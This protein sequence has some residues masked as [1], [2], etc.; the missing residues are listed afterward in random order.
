[1]TTKSS[2]IYL[3]D[4]GDFLSV[5]S[6]GKSQ[7]YFRHK[8]KNVT[9]YD[10]LPNG[11]E[12]VIC[13]ESDYILL[14]DIEGNTINGIKTSLFGIDKIKVLALSDTQILIYFT[15]EY[16]T[17]Y[18]SKS[19]V[20]WDLSTNT[21]SSRTTYYEGI[22][23]NNHYNIDRGYKISNN[24][25]LM[26]HSGIGNILVNIQTGKT[27]KLDIQDTNNIRVFGSIVISFRGDKVYV[28]RIDNETGIKTTEI[29]GS[30]IFNVIDLT[31]DGENYLYIVMG[32]MNSR[33]INR[34]DMEGKGKKRV[35]HSAMLGNNTDSFILYDSIKKRIIYSAYRGVVKFI[36]VKP[37]D[38]KYFYS[39]TINNDIKVY[40]EITNMSR[41]RS[42]R[43][44]VS[45]NM[46]D[47]LNP[48]VND[49][50][51]TIIARMISV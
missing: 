4:A 6:N 17:N 23:V 20:I 42:Y 10:I 39:D 12:M 16:V 24:T 48:Y 36:A 5:E 44:L 49:R 30:S 32:S 2:L 3:N 45:N 33:I 28:I 18:V 15:S 26:S 22:I 47:V 11:K 31:Y 35:L 37:N 46:V 19:F 40:D 9:D 43:L 1:M 38:K 13:F 7:Q 34:Y 41:S 21:I 14:V 27:T 51:S 50:I 8:D 25:V 29:S